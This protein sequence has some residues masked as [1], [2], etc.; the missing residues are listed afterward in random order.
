MADQGI[1]SGA[2]TRD[3]LVEIGTEELPPKALRG[4]SEAFRDGLAG[5]LAAHRLA[6][7]SVEALASPRRLAVRVRAVSLR[8]PDV[9]VELKGPPAD[10]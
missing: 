6:A 4:L 10:E 2:E 3:F 1:G 9:E 5:G 8:Q 7:A